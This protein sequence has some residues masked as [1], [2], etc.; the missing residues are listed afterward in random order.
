MK[1]PSD[2]KKNPP[3]HFGIGGLAGTFIHSL[4]PPMLL[5]LGLLLGILALFDS[6]IAQNDP[7]VLATT[8]T[9]VVAQII[10]ASA[11]IGLVTIFV[12]GMRSAITIL[13]AIAFAVSGSLFWTTMS[14]YEADGI[15]L[16]GLLFAI[17]IV[18]SDAFV[19]T[20]TIYQRWLSNGT[21]TADSALHALHEIYK[22]MIVGSLCIIAAILSLALAGSPMTIDLRPL[23]AFGWRAVALSVLAVFLII[24]WFTVRMRPGLRALQ[25]AAAKN[26]KLNGAI[27]RY[28]QPAMRS[29][30][31]N[32][33][34]VRTFIAVLVMG[35]LV[36]ATLLITDRASPSITGNFIETA[37]P[38]DSPGNNES[39]SITGTGEPGDRQGNRSSYSSTGMSSSIGLAYSGALIVIYLL[40]FAGIRNFVLPLVVMIPIPLSL[41][42]ILPGHWLMN[43]DYSAS[44][45]V[46]IVLLAGI[47][48]RH[49]LLIVNTTQRQILT[50]LTISEAVLD[51]VASHLQSIVT[52]TLL[53]MVTAQAMRSMPVFQG[54]AVSLISGLSAA[55]LLSLVAI[56]LACI[57]ASHA[58]SPAKRRK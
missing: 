57:S 24:P 43:V 14:G 1:L 5:L 45:Q 21:A 39:S 54:L 42:G 22:P 31:G 10:V 47:L 25:V 19:I 7:D 37:Q 16:T 29:F 30:L 41:L 4:L 49:S 55:T 56:P 48:V 53:V 52:T 11:G 35:C 34:L 20:T 23:A 28:Y 27:A 33:A 13:L 50:G 32:G 26:S 9:A 36:S 46:G 6:Q 18:A 44:S 2:D 38:G 12:L 17:G 51:A 58:F 3:H 40:L 8:R 15:G